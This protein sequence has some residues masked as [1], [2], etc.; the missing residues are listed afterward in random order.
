M[1]TNFHAKQTTLTFLTQIY[2]EM[3]LGFEI[4]ETNVGIRISILE[5][6]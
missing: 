1:S 4:Q 3:D 6:L 2:P 5:I